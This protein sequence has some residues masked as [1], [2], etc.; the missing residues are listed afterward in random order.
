MTS[1]IYFLFPAVQGLDS[2]L[3]KSMICRE[4][5]QPNAERTFN[6][7]W[8]TADLVSNLFGEKNTNLETVYLGQGRTRISGHSS[9]TMTLLN[10][11]IVLFFRSKVKPVY[12]GS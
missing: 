6:L 10:G 11:L 2:R 9:L 5:K 12:N 7:H 4:R 8:Q 1:T 3:G